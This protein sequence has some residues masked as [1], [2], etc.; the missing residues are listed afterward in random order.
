MRN[1]RIA[2]H[3]PKDFDQARL[4]SWLRVLK[5]P[6]D[7]N[8]PLNVPLNPGLAW[9]RQVLDLSLELSRAAGFPIFT[10]ISVRNCRQ[11]GLGGTQWIANCF[12]YDFSE[13][14]TLPLIRV[15]HASF[16]LAHWAHGADSSLHSDRLDFY[17]RAEKQVS[18]LFKQNSQ[19]GKST[20]HI[21]EAAH[22]LGIP[23]SPL[24]H[25]VYQL[26]WGSKA[27]LIERSTTEHDSAIGMKWSGNKIMTAQ[28][29]RSAGLPA[30]TH[31]PVSNLDQARE[32]AKR[33]GYPVVLKPADAERGE[34]VS[35]DVN[36][37]SLEPAFNEAMRWSSG[38]VALVER[39][40][41]G[42]SHRLWICNG[43][44]LYAV[45]RLPL[46]LYAD[47][48][49]TIR[50]LVDAEYHKQQELPPWKRSKIRPLDA[51]AIQLL[52]TRGLGP[53]STPG[54]GEYIALRRFQTTAGGGVF[55]EVTD[56]VHPANWDAAVSAARLLGLKVA[57]VD[58]ITS[59]VK[60]PWYESGAI[61]SE[62]NFA[63][64][65]G[66]HETGRRYIPTYLNRLLGGNGRIPIEVFVGGELAWQAAK[67]RQLDLFS[68][69]KKA[70]ITSG[71]ETLA[72][73]RV[74]KEQLVLSW[75]IEGRPHH[76]SIRG[77]SARTRG[78]LMFKEVEALVLVVQDDELLQSRPP[79]DRVDSVSFIDSELRQFGSQEIGRLDLDR[80]TELRQLLADWSAGRL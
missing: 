45:N 54:K 22:Q 33:L 58:F 2:F 26:G 6:V 48:Q 63:P 69:D 65:L 71:N 74:S 17:N 66:I 30:P 24:P 37:T 61:I 12:S 19:R 51:L 20:F 11:D 60:V 55:E 15:I 78:L 21:L 31:F 49:S 57:G 73:P 75:D 25:G 13:L 72:P 27:R 32:V 79:V 68:S 36:E 5:A 7:S 35:V 41:P 18:L 46:G 62:V 8:R 28:L 40:V 44:P 4:E 10:P 9:L 50:E 59:D 34:G 76:M 3:T 39:Q 23:Y 29:L 56:L 80:E 16:G 64:M 52:E 42:I 43:E 67:S 38:K 1:L 47:G 14:T 77:L 70:W 53:D